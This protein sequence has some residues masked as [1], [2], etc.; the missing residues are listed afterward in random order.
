M[1]EQP[2][3]SPSPSSDKFEV[4]YRQQLSALIDG[5]LP[6]DEARF[7]LRR[8]QH[9]DELG[10]CH[11]RWQLCGDVLRG[12]ASAP[13]PVDFAARVRVAV[14]AEP[15][16]ASQP[17]P[18]RARLWGW[19]GGAIAASVA[20]LALFVSRERLPEQTAPAPTAVFATTAQVPVAPVP[21]PADPDGDNAI[22][23]MAAAAPAAALAAARR[24]AGSRNVASATRVQ[25][26]ARASAARRESPPQVQV[27]SVAPPVRA[28]ANPVVPADPF[29]H[30]APVQA[31]PWPRS[32]L[33]GSESSLNASFGETPAT[34]FYPFEPAQAV[35]MED[36]RLPPMPR[37]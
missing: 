33:A 34:T 22:G 15:V 17:A 9:D 29:G 5:E 32:A 24:D 8:L 37:P 12:M 20:A 19:G 21:A 11:E 23:R 6:A 28:I 16:P 31:R 18:T 27:A 7:L 3:Q 1:K 2:S 26:A 13:A 35:P 14:A 36:E 4:H 25:Q 30:P 10:G